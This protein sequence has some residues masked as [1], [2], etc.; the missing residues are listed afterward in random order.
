MSDQ[1]VFFK[2]AIDKNRLSHLYLLNGV[3]GSGKLTLA[4]EIAHLLLKDYDKKDNLLDNILTDNNS[5]V[6]HIKPDG[7]VIKKEQI[8]TLQK[9]FTKTSLIRAPRIYIIEDI[10]LISTSAANSLLKFME[11]PENEMVYGFL[12]SSNLSNV[13]PTI[14]S[15][16]QV[17]RIDDNSEPNYIID[18]LVSENSGS[19]EARMIS[20]LTKNKDESLELLNDDN[21]VYIIN[22]IKDFISKYPSKSFSANLSI[23]KELSNILYDRKYYLY[24]LE[25][26][27][28]SFV[29][30]LKYKLKENI[31]IIELEEVYR[32]E[33][34]SLNNDIII[35]ASNLIQDEIS[36][37]NTYI[38]VGLSLEVLMINIK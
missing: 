9:E 15:R 38:N 4:Y 11:E 7:N 17:V 14:T 33:Y 29:D 18:Y 16:S 12:I 19:Y 10:D 26:L 28:V 27:L 20:F 2:N 5:Q 31:D 37:L 1:L 8:L 34:K 24:F 23:T 3:K 6:H 25:L 36:K 21:I 22:F 13:L 35:T 30:V 32:V